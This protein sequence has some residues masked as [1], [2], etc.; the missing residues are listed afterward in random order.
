MDKGAEFRL[1]TYGT[2]A[3]GRPNHHKLDDLTGTWIEGH[4]RGRLVAQGWGAELGYP[5]IILDEAA[6]RV[7]V[8]IFESGDLPAH[9]E[10]FDAFE[11]AEYKRTEAWADTN[12]GRL[13]VSIYALA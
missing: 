12:N 2:L 6:D 10:R 8:F 5:A 11:G 3:P 9:W 1:A 4:V 7:A 13:R